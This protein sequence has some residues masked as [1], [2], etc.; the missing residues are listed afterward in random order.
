MKLLIVRTQK[1]LTFIHLSLHYSLH[2]IVP[3]TF[4]HTIFIN[5]FGFQIIIFHFIHFSIISEFVIKYYKLTYFHY[6][7]KLDEFD[8]VCKHI[9]KF[10]QSQNSPPILKFELHIQTLNI[11]KR[12][13]GEDHG[14]FGW[15]IL[16]KICERC[17]EDLKETYL[18]IMGK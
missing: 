11:W 1:C 18:L 16:S 13:Q 6:I 4:H 15:H 2:F 12:S 7:S 8:D 17:V 10:Q 5:T 3:L 9:W 14:R